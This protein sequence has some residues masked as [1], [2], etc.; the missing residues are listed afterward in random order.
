MACSLRT[1]S[2]P[3]EYILTGQI[4]TMGPRSGLRNA[5]P[6]DL[7]VRGDSGTAEWTPMRLKLMGPQSGLTYIQAHP[8]ELAKRGYITMDGASKCPFNSL[9]ETLRGATEV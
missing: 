3:D 5:R 9:S 7:E 6:S 4:R 1:R 8:I 2:S